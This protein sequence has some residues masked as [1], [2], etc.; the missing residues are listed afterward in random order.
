MAFSFKNQGIFYQIF[1]SDINDLV[2]YVDSYE[3]FA[4]IILLII[5][6]VE[7]VA[8]PI[9]GMIIYVAAG[10][11]LGSFMGGLISFIGNIIG[12]TICFYLAWQGRTSFFKKTK[13]KTLV[14]FDK[15]SIKYGGLAIFLLRLNPL[16]STDIISYIA[17][18]SK[19]K[20]KPFIIGTSLGLLPLSFLSSYFGGELIIGHPFLYNFF[21]FVSIL[22]FAGAIYLLYITKAFSTVRTVEK[23]IKENIQNKIKKRKTNKI[24]KK[25]IKNNKKF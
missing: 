12:S 11:I 24:N 13:S 20:F 25:K 14:S 3:S 4:P 7:V 16:T 19:L 1:N 8:A 5:I 15:Y 17:G 21:I 2:D 18:F 6:I 22:Y 10:V 9:P 23:K